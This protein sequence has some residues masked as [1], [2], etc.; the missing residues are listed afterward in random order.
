MSDN[1]FVIVEGREQIEAFI[2][3]NGN[4]SISS[5]GDEYNGQQVIELRKK[6]AL[7]L[8]RVLRKLALE[9]GSKSPIATPASGGAI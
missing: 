8:A 5:E 3:Q 1:I 9:V 6:D 7:A 4:I 2:N